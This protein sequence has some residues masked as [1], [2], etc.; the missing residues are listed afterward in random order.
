MED[1]EKKSC[2][3]EGVVYSHG[4]LRCNDGECK[5]CDDGNWTDPSKLS[6]HSSKRGLYVA[7]GKDLSEL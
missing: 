5:V 3:F 4:L 7:P 6:P 1:L 2:I